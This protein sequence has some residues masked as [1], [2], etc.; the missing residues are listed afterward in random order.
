MPKRYTRISHRSSIDQSFFLPEHSRP[1]AS[2]CVPSILEKSHE[3][4]IALLVDWTEPSSLSTSPAFPSFPCIALQTRAYDLLLLFNAGQSFAAVAC[5]A[6]GWPRKLSSSMHVGI[7]LRESFTCLSLAL[8][9]CVP[10]RVFHIKRG[11]APFFL[12]QHCPVIS[13]PALE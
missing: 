13:C 6:V 11:L 12:L 7:F 5:S 1:A 9:A 10:F 8:R 2:D 3:L 4:A